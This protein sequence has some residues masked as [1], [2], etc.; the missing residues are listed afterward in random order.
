MGSQPS[1]ISGDS[2]ETSGTGSQ[3]AS[4]TL[5]ERTY[6]MTQDHLKYMALEQADLSG[7]FTGFRVTV[8]G[9]LDNQT[10]ASRGFPGS[11]EERFQQAGRINGYV[12]ELAADPAHPDQD[13]AIFM[14]ATVAH[15]FET[16]GSVEA[17]M[18][19]VFL[20]EF[21]KNEGREVG[22]GQTL[23]SV[24]ELEPSGFFDQAVALKVVHDNQ[25]ALVS[26]TVVD[27]RVGRLLG[28]AL[29]GV[30]GNHVR[31]DEAS[32]LGIALERRIVSVVLGA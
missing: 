8:E 7:A 21:A 25:G 11:T 3:H 15:L 16:P 31:L 2:G 13:G 17:W 20:A 28:V 5:L 19:E 12:R 26:S 23:V 4:T 9:L 29:V 22:G 30:S 24:E 18:R 6:D 14:A 32:E 1:Q 27:F 10:M